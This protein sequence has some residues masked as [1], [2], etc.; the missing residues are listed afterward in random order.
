MQRPTRGII[1]VLLVVCAGCGKPQMSA[2]QIASAESA[3]SDALEA[4]QSQDYAAALEH[5]NTAINEAGLNPDLLCDAF[6]YSAECHIELGNLE[7]AAAVL[8]SLEGHAP[9]MDKFH[10]VRCK[11]YAK[12]GDDAKARAAL[13]AAREINP[14]VEPPLRLN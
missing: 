8:E 11:L 10:L 2:P 12:Q 14:H 1:L 6:L 4:L 13:N 7:E 5:F 3:Y 9:E